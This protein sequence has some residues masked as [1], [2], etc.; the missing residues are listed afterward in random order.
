M[1]TINLSEEQAKELLTSF[2]WRVINFGSC[3]VLNLNHEIAHEIFV[4]LENK[5]TPASTE[6]ANLAAWRA[7]AGYTAK[8]VEDWKRK[9]EAMEGFE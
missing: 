6:A 5:L 3:D 4:Q 2:G 1:I 7:E 8:A 9:H